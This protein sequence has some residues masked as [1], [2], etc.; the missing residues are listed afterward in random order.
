MDEVIEEVITPLTN[1]VLVR[2]GVKR[3]KS[4]YYNNFL[5]EKYSQVP[6]QRR[7]PSI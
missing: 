1:N 6:L 5:H 7:R 2:G 4:I 3:L